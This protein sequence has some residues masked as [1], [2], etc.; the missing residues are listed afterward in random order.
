MD[1]KFSTW[2]PI[3]NRY[4]P[5]D[6]WVV[7]KRGASLRV[8][9]TLA[10]LNSINWQR[11]N[12][13]LLVL[14]DE[15]GDNHKAFF[16]DHDKATYVVLV[17]EGEQTD[18]DERVKQFKD[19][20]HL[21]E[22]KHL[23][24]EIDAILSNTN[25]CLV[26][27]GD[28]KF[29]PVHTGMWKWKKEKVDRVG[30]FD[31][32]VFKAENLRVVMKQRMEH[33]RE[34]DVSRLNSISATMKDL[35]RQAKKEKSKK[36]KEETEEDDMDDVDM[37]DGDII[38]MDGEQADSAQAA[39][40]TS[41]QR[42]R[43]VSSMSSAA[44]GRSGVSGSASSPGKMNEEQFL[45]LAE[46]QKNS[47]LHATFRPSLPLPPPPSVEF[48]DYLTCCRPEQ[49]PPIGRPLRLVEH[50]RDIH[51]TVWMC[52][53]FPLTKQQIS[54]VLEVLGP[55]HRHVDKLREFLQ[56]SLPSGFPVRVR[57]PVI[58][59]VTAEIT[60][61]DFILQENDHKD[62]FA[63]PANYQ[64]KL[65]PKKEHAK[66]SASSAKIKASPSKV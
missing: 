29:T 63:V 3:V 13:T 51:G 23:A 26:A 49:R 9:M 44:S 12:Y 7:Y 64:L 43:S 25:T 35:M 39:S 17:A 5:S 27:E 2:L 10:E 42:T 55:H 62:M 37:S 38:G 45:S 8:D 33:L 20:V 18:E 65:P 61:S 47:L 57:L 60:F 48:A 15:K 58:P 46:E 66:K 22:E 56:Y 34:E 31:A 24:Q 28:I 52:D 54:H 36:P 1:W 4:L 50:K 59:T 40:A 16:L 21:M 30:K 32:R 53:N 14:P 6:N 19:D 41:P 11:G